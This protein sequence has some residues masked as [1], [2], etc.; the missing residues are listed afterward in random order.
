[1]GRK[2]T[3]LF[4]DYQKKK[5]KNELANKQKNPQTNL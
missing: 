5:K 3:D 2:N 4:I 1:M